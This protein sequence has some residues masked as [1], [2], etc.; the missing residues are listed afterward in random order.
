MPHVIVL[1]GLRRSGKSTL[2]RQIIKKYCNDQTFYYINFEDERLL[3]FEAN[4]FNRL[5]EAS[6]SL[7]GE[8]KIFFIDEIQNVAH[9]DIFVRRFYRGRFQ[10]CNYRFKR[11]FT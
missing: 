3:G 8:N 7:F 1:T 6:V 4:E 2:L 10:I 5:Y 11:R 9:F